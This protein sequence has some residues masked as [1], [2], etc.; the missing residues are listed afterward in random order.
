MSKT[1]EIG[2][3]EVGYDVFVHDGDVKVGAVRAVHDHS[4]VVYVENGGDFS[5]ARHAVAEVVE[6]KVVLRCD[7]LDAALKRAINHAHDAED[8]AAGVLYPEPPA[9]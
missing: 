5:V 4:L 6:G 7:Q 9:D 3:I 8:A 1:N 2:P